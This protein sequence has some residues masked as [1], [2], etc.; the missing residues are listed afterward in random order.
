MIIKHSKLFEC[1]NKHGVEYIL[2]GGTLAIAYG[3]PRVTKDIDIFL[4]PNPG[5]AARLLDALK[6]FGMGTAELTTPEDVCATEVTIFKD[7][8]RLDVLTAVKGLEFTS[9]WQGKVF[10]ELD[11]VLIPALS[12]DDLI[13]AKKASAR[14]R[15]FEDIKVLKAIYPKK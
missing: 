10:L 8:V 13:R 6:E 12:V 11:K 9:A 7:V 15:D 14:P 4:N 3:I 5:N 1:L 2:I